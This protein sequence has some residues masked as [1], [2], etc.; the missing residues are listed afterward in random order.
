MRNRSSTR[1]IFPNHNRRRRTTFVP[2]VNIASRIR[3]F[4]VFCLLIA[5]DSIY[6]SPFL[7]RNVAELALNLPGGPK[8]RFPLDITRFFLSVQMKIAAQCD[9]SEILR[10]F[11]RDSFLESR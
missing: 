10:D 2:I 4:L 9:A 5:I 1:E 3:C 7:Y 8:Y 11:R 6:S